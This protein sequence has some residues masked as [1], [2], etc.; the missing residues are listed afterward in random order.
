MEIMVETYRPLRVSRSPYTKRRRASMG[1]LSF[2]PTLGIFLRIYARS[3]PSHPY[4]AAYSI[5]VL[6]L[7]FASS[8][9]HGTP[10]SPNINIF[11]CRIMH[12][13]LPAFLWIKK[14]KENPPQF[15]FFISIRNSETSITVYS[16]I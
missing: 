9:P 5:P 6:S 11:V 8:S 2:I 16:Q 12:A 13:D 4:R 10:G 3:I 14:R 15:F 7:L 1:T